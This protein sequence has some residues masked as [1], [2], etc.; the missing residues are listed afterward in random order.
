[1]PEASDTPRDDRARA[2]DLVAECMNRRWPAAVVAR[3]E[4]VR[5]D[6]SSRRYVRCRLDTGSAG[7]EV[8]SSVVVMLMDDAAVAL[9]SDELGVYGA[10]GPQELPF[11]NV[12]RFLSR[13]TDALP[14]IYLDASDDGGLVLEDV[15]DVP[16]WDAAA[17][18]DIERRFAEALDLLAAIQL[19]AVDDGSGCYAF[20]QAFDERLF[21]WEFEH[22]VEYGLAGAGALADCRAELAVAA[23][24]LAQL[25]RVFCHRDYHA[26]NIHVHDGRLRVIDFQDALLGPALYDVASL[27]TDRS[28]PEA[29]DPEME[30]RLVLR[31]ADA[32]AA[33][34]NGGTADAD[35]L[36]STYRLCAFQRVLKVIG[37]FNY[38]AEV[39]NKPSYLDMLPTVVATARR[40]AAELDDV[41]ATA[42][43]LDSAVKDGR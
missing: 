14:E 28:T 18:D 31:Y 3:V 32:V 7:V 17:D 11:V 41:A 9:S 12:W 16:L 27:L 2:G 30:R 26:W 21:A 39:K 42:G 22:F 38:L 33:G 37:R 1:M 5:G 40:L 23:R 43:L 35:E 4:P 34:G 13:F 36:M 10:D 6:A 20:A 19:R 8:P 24:R 15:G 29:V 25:P